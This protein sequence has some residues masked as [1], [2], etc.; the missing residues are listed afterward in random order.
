MNY[1]FNKVRMSTTAKSSLPANLQLT[2]VVLTP[3]LVLSVVSWPVGDLLSPVG[4]RVLQHQ[5]DVLQTVVLVN[6]S[7]EAAA[8]EVSHGQT[9]PAP[10]P[11]SL[12]DY[13]FLVSFWFNLC[14]NVLVFTQI[15][16][17]ITDLPGDKLLI[18][19]GQSS[20]HGGGVLLQ[21]GSLA[22][23]HF[24]DI[25]SDPQVSRVCRTAGFTVLPVWGL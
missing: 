20:E 14:L 6:P 22:W 4:Q 7:E 15:R 1:N 23:Q 10:T 25:I 3:L 2:D 24:Y 11:G 12:Q 5:S 19:S 9:S 13:C 17:L 18:L 21:G 16:S 8:S